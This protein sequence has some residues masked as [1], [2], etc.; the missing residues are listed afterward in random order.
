VYL[1]EEREMMAMI[2]ISIPIFSSNPAALL[3]LAET[4]MLTLSS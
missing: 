3:L 1:K 4:M 2:N